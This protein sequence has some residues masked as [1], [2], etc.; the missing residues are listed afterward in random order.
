MHIK[1]LMS[2]FIF[3]L[4]GYPLFAKNESCR[5]V[6]CLRYFYLPVTVGQWP[7]QRIED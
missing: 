3:I 7:K 2:N 1:M 4:T 5:D 6:T